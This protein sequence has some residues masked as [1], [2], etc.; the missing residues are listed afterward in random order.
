MTE[1]LGLSTDGVTVERPFRL[2][3]AG[4]AVPGILWLPHGAPS[5]PPLVLLGHGG[6]GHKRSEQLVSLAHSFAGQAG[7][8]VLAIDGPYH[9]DRVA[10]PVP[11]AVYQ[12][13]IAEEGAEAVLDRMVDDWLGCVEAL[14]ETADGSRLG[15]L[16]MS[17]GA[18]FGL[19]LAARVGNRL[20]CLVIG[21]FGLDAVAAMDPRYQLPERVA[22]DAR[23]VSAPTLFHVQW[24]DEIFPRSGQFALFDLLGAA[25]KQ[26]IAFPGRHAET[27]ANALP[28]W[29]EFVVRR[30][31]K[32]Q[33]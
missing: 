28:V 10:A 15:Y 16:G 31:L 6:S 11:A 5:R 2:L 17:M 3:R 26:L 9:G 7:L 13:L 23:S 14:A 19:S 21:K 30:L 1:W 32:T 33:L 25:D 22:R 12:R 20:Q 8:A 27:P 24:Q 18:R 4:H 29:R